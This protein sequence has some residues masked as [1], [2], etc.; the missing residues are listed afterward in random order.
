MPAKGR[1]AG[2]QAT[3]S[4]FRASGCSRSKFGLDFLGLGACWNSHGWDEPEAATIVRMVQ[5][6]PV[7]SAVIIHI[8]LYD[9]GVIHRQLS[10]QTGPKW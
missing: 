8:V 9:A 6:A 1:A 5:A 2:L 10:P 3:G 7:I 4:K